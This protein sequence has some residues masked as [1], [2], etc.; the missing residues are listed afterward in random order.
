MIHFNTHILSH[1]MSTHRGWKQHTQ[2]LKER[3][4]SL[5]NETFPAEHQSSPYLLPRLASIL[6]F[7]TK[8][9][10]SHLACC[11]A[12]RCHYSHYYTALS[13]PAVRD[14]WREENTAESH[15]RGAEEE[16]YTPTVS[17][18]IKTQILLQVLPHY[19]I[20]NTLEIPQ[21]CNWTVVI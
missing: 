13:F 2:S 11:C 15:G 5:G 16:Q 6:L 12:A 20:I 3:G 7:V 18:L 10:N 21:P 19:N 17:F 8:M 4:M 14:A 1:K 9:I